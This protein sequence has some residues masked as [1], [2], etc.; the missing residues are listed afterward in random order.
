MVSELSQMLRSDQ[1]HL[2]YGII[3]NCQISALIHSSGKISWCCMPRMDSG[4]VF[5]ALLD[6]SKGG[7]WS[8]EP[9]DWSG[10]QFDQEYLRNTNV[11]KTLFQHEEAGLAFEI[12]DF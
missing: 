7:F 6:E 11:L 5:G 9:A 2:D 3:G 8:I 1:G 10:W 4:S 12:I